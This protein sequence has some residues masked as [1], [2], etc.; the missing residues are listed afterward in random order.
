MTIG[1]PHPPVLILAGSRGS[2]DPVAQALGVSHKAIAP[3]AGIPM[4]ER[5][6]NT[7]REALPQSHLYVAIED[8]AAALSIPLVDCLA[9]AGTLSV[10]PTGAT[11]CLSILSLIDGNGLTPPVLVTTADHPL[12]TPAMVRHFLTH[13]PPGIDAAAGVA[14]QTTIEASHPGIPR[15]YLRFSDQ[16]VSGCN[17]F[18]LGAG[19]S[20]VLTFWRRLEQDRKRPL[21]MIRHL[22]I[23]S[24]ILFAMG[25]L[26]LNSAVRRLGRR[27][28]A[29]AWAVDMPF[30]EAAI[31]VDRKTD[32]DLAERL[33]ASR[34]P[35]RS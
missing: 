23:V 2:A 8:P 33:L 12:L 11:P 9:K 27:A 34:D 29:V 30:A 10:V 26:S 1:Q 20:R 21:A 19:A 15:T 4:L 35:A 5:V 22:G 28:G 24:L 32:I 3:I 13:L 17:L 6:I 31:D 16:A 7:L 25:R 14:R 18:W